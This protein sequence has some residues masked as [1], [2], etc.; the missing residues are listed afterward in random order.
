MCLTDGNGA[1]SPPTPSPNQYRRVVVSVLSRVG[2]TTS[3]L[4]MPPLGIGVYH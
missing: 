1:R 2:T 3:E 4:T